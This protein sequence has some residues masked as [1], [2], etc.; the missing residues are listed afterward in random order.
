MTWVR[1]YLRNIRRLQNEA[2]E[3][4]KPATPD[5]VSAFEGSLIEIEILGKNL[6]ERNKKYYS[7]QLINFNYRT[8]P[9]MN[10]QQEGFQ[11][12]PLH[13]GETKI[14]FRGYVWT[15]NDIE[16]YK[17]MRDEEDFELIGVIDGSVKAAMES[18]GDELERYLT[19]AGESN[20]DIPKEPKKKIPKQ[21]MASP[22]FSVFKGFGEL[23]GS[24]GPKKVEKIRGI[25][26]EKKMGSVELEGEKHRAHEFTKKT[27]YHCYRNFKKAHR[28]LSW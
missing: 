5:L 17:K 16:N 10:Y 20:I 23:F 22:F 18:L 19:E 27:L 7:C 11:R 6:P 21:M 24:L 25:K 13:V 12:G 26:T 9:S 14:T 1:P 15:E 3:L 2:M 4:K 8:R 28:M